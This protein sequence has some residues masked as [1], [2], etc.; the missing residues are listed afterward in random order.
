MKPEEYNE[1]YREKFHD[2]ADPQRV[3]TVSAEG[4]VTYKALLFIP[5]ATPFDFYTKEYE[6][7]LQLYSSGVLI[8]DKCAGSAA[9]ALPVRPGRGG[10]PGSEPEHLPGAFAA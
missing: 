5:G 9:G 4:A 8:M 1:F 6:K 10:F 3:I 7:G 2:F